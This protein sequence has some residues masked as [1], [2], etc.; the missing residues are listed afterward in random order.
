MKKL[1]QLVT[2]SAV[3]ATFAL[4]ALAQEPTASPS[5]SPSPAATAAQGGQEDEAAKTALYEK[6]QANYKTNQ[7]VAY[8][9]AKEYLQ[10]YPN[11]TDKARVDWLQKYVAKYEAA[12]VQF[13]L[14]E[15][16]KN[17]KYPEAFAL[18]KQ[19][20]AKEPENLNVMMRL[21]YAGYQ[22]A[23]AKNTAF[24]ADAI[25]YTKQAI[26]MIESGK[27]P[28]TWDPFTNK[29]EA[30]AYLNYAL[31][32]LNL[33]TNKDQALENL[34]RAAQ[35]E[36]IKKDPTTYT[37]LVYAYE[38]GPY[39]KA[40][41]AYEAV[42][43]KPDTPE[44]KA[45]LES[46]NTVT[47]KLIDAYARAVAYATDPKLQ[48]DKTKWMARLT[49]LY[50]FRHNNEVAG[51][52]QLIANVRNTPVPSPSATP[53]TPTAPASG[54]ATGTDSGAA[55]GTTTSGNTNATGTTSTTPTTT[56]TPANTTQPST[57]TPNTTTQPN[58]TMQPSGNPKPTPTPTP[59]QPAKKP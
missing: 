18:G 25:N 41:D 52:D 12:S 46:L 49:E 23:Y 1:I 8:E 15:L 19:I 14:P 9:A 33:E 16:I 54:A 4:P 34:V 21:G 53:T 50:K 7:P 47:D 28:Q 57:T 2:L 32:F 22:A 24:N 10:K 5:A 43:S 42:S 37:Y 48:A 3:V 56:T 40:T 30:L 6:V 31:G 44:F 17:K 55:V 11:E 58:T 20:L 26:A 13:Q 39:K 35:N 27:S 36:T 59:T 29:D 38:T 51:L 45:A